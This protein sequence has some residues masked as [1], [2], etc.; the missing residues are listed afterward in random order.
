MQFI[1]HMRMCLV[2]VSLDT[3]W[4]LC[5]GLDW[6][7]WW[8]PRVLVETDWS[9]HTHALRYSLSLLRC[10][11]LLSIPPSTQLPSSNWLMR[12]S[13]TRGKSCQLQWHEKKNSQKRASKKRETNALATRQKEKSENA[14]APPSENL[15]PLFFYL[16]FYLFF[17]SC[18]RELA[19]ATEPL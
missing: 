18:F 16:S 11:S 5:A 8:H 2:L 7:E 17:R 1:S 13:S 19:S 4:M 12:K 10:F 15:P 9:P 6:A 3:A 14:V